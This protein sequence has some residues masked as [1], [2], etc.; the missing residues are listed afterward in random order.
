L[1]VKYAEIYAA[2]IKTSDL[3]IMRNCGHTPHEEQPNE[4][5]KIILSHLQEYS[6]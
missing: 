1:N 4:T 2:K 3:T 5:L 6:F